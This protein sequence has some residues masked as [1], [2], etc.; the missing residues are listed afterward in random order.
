MKKLLIIVVVLSVCLNAKAQFASSAK[1]DKKQT[2]YLSPVFINQ[3][4]SSENSQAPG[5]T[6]K[7][8]GIAL[9]IIGGIL[10][11][12]GV[13]VLASTDQ[14]TTTTTYNG[15][16]EDEGPALGEIMI[17]GG[18]GMMVPGIILWSK[19]NNKYK[20]YQEEQNASINLKGAGISLKLRF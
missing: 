18:V 8:T 17:A 10:V 1:I 15:T 2:A 20:D 19:G 9:T 14:T 5:L 7:N 13:G 16:I 3:S 6:M 4:N 12:V 11:T